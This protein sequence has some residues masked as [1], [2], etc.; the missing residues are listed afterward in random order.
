MVKLFYTQIDCN[1]RAS[2]YTQASHLLA[3]FE[4]FENYLVRNWEY[5][6]Q[7]WIIFEQIWRFRRVN[8]RATKWR[9][10]ILYNNLNNTYGQVAGMHSIYSVVKEFR[11]CF[12]GKFWY[13]IVLLFHLE[14]IYLPVLK[15]VWLKVVLTAFLSISRSLLK[16][17][18]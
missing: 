10:G 11:G 5:L 7:N 15:Y 18:Y 12:K 16:Q 14:A 2:G 8:T 17:C 13:S 1:T 3:I 9:R 4:S 6:E